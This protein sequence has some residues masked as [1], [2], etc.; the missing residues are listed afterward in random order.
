MDK[1]IVI[2][3]VSFNDGYKKY[4]YLYQGDRQCLRRGN[5]YQFVRGF[6]KK[7]EAYDIITIRDY[8]ETDTL[9]SI[10]TTSLKIENKYIKTQIISSDERQKLRNDYTIQPIKVV[11][12]PIVKAKEKIRQTYWTIWEN[13]VYHYY[14]DKE[15]L[16]TFSNPNVQKCRAYSL[17]HICEYLISLIKQY[18]C[19]EFLEK[20]PKVSL[21]VLTQDKEWAEQLYNYYE[22]KGGTDLWN[23]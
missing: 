18:D 14:A 17:M 15:A 23:K 21:E 12:P 13:K 19:S 20:Q 11:A 3:S 5:K 10:V 9:P 22:Q 8:F 6:N 1:K 7:G 4:Q 16:I 2:V